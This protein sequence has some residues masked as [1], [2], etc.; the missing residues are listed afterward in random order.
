MSKDGL[1]LTNAVHETFDM[2][3]GLTDSKGSNRRARVGA[4]K[5]ADDH[6]K[7]D[8]GTTAPIKG[9]MC[10]NPDPTEFE[11]L[12]K[13]S[14]EELEQDIYNVQDGFARKVYGIFS[15]EVL[16]MA[17][18]VFFVQLNKE[19]VAELHTNNMY[20][21]IAIVLALGSF[22][23]IIAGM[24]SIQRKVPVNYILAFVNCLAMSFIAGRIT[25][26]M[27]INIVLTSFILTFIITLGLFFAAPKIIASLTK[28]KGHQLS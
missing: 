13:G 2:E 27:N 26:T 28:R 4:V 22:I 3:G 21:I 25:Y 5:C 7:L 8:D 19:S 16:L 23:A 14:Q 1:Y 12:G 17:S 6:Y 9:P 18:W 11:K 15:V 24:K 10:L 20:L